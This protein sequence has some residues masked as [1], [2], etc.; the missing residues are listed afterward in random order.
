MFYSRDIHDD[1]IEDEIREAFRCFDKDG[2]GFIPVTGNYCLERAD[3]GMID[4][5]VLFLTSINQ[6]PFC[7][8]VPSFVKCW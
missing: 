8:F 3:A 1:E 6:L 2:H 4:F 5:P 7:R